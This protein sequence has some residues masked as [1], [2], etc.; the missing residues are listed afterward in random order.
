MLFRAVC[1]RLK[2]VGK[3]PQYQGDPFL[4]VIAD[5]NYLVTR[6]SDGWSFAW[7]LADRA[8]K[9]ESRDR[10]TVQ[11]QAIKEASGESLKGEPFNF[12]WPG[13]ANRV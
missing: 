10:T 3:T 2:N 5:C 6:N 7:W 4:Y 12:S 9:C 1:T 11:Q 13:S 8:L